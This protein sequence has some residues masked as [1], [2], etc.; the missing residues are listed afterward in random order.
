MLGITAAI[1]MSATAPALADIGTTYPYGA[2]G[3]VVPYTGV[4]FYI[5]SN[6]MRRFFNKLRLPLY[7]P[8]V[9]N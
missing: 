8:A 2:H 9:K 7:R 5:R 6:D 3:R 1:P 4:M